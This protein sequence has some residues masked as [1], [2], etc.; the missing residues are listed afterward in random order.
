MAALRTHGRVMF[1]LC[2]VVVLA[3]GL[4]ADLTMGQTSRKMMNLQGRLT[5]VDGNPTTG[6]HLVELAIYDGSSGGNRLY[7]EAQIVTITKGIYN[8]LVGDGYAAFQG[9]SPANY[10]VSGGKTGGIPVTVFNRDDIWLEIEIDEDNPLTPRT[11]VV[12]SAYAFNADTL[13]GRDWSA[14]GAITATS[15]AASGTVSGATVNGT[16]GA[17]TNFNT[18]NLSF[19]GGGSINSSKMASLQALID[20]P[21]K[22]VTQRVQLESHSGNASMDHDVYVTTFTKNSASSNLRFTYSDTFFR[23][24][25]GGVDCYWYIEYGLGNYNTTA[26]SFRFDGPQDGRQTSSCGHGWNHNH[27]AWG[28]DHTYYDS[29]TRRMPVS[30]VCVGGAVAAGNYQVRVRMTGG[31]NCQIDDMGYGVLLVDEVY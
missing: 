23:N 11:R 16:D 22:T 21:P 10:A 26:C 6:N 28:H 5:D 15:L 18:A 3:M 12:S 13:D 19:Q 29:W 7:Y 17:I 25:T 4:V 24:T 2:V 1:G 31:G 14:A 9:T 8:I 20:T 27:G 30:H